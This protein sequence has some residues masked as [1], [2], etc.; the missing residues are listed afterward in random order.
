MHILVDQYIN[1][2]NNNNA[3]EICWLEALMLLQHISSWCSNSEMRKPFHCVENI[4]AAVSSSSWPF[5][6]LNTMPPNFLGRVSRYHKKSMI[7]QI[8]LKTRLF[9]VTLVFLFLW[10]IQTLHPNCVQTP[11][12]QWLVLVRTEDRGTSNASMHPMALLPPFFIY[13]SFEPQR[14]RLSDISTGTQF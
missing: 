9:P 4:I 12:H 5:L 1:N 8:K 10:W 3:K 2:N 14:S 7:G 6:L 11:S 13:L